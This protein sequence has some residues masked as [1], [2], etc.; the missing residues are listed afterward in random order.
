[1]HTTQSDYNNLKSDIEA[2]NAAKQ[3]YRDAMQEINANTTLSEN[4]K[5]RRMKE[6]AQ[7]ESAASNAAL[8]SFYAHLTTLET[9]ITEDMKVWYNSDSP[10]LSIVMNLINAGQQPDLAMLQPFMGD[11]VTMNSLSAMLDT[12]S[13][14]NI[15][16]PYTLSEAT[17]ASSVQRA[18]AAIQNARGSDNLYGANAAGRIVAALG[19][20][21]GH[22]M[23]MGFNTDEWAAA[24][25]RGAGLM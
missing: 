25:M 9:H 16:K 10:A 20:A 5:S 11:I 3:W 14:E 12:K 23:G 6:A 24:A 7:A 1:M 4:E 13:L 15:A 17:L 22:D 2:M 21:T 19:P 18:V 8:E